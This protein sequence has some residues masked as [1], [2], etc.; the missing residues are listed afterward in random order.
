[1]FPALRVRVSGLKKLSKYRLYL[2]FIPVDRNKYRYVYHR[3]VETN[4]Q[5]GNMHIQSSV[6][7]NDH[8]FHIP[9]TKPNAIWLTTLD[10][11]K[12]YLIN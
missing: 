6:N 2:D 9:S 4:D 8:E 10:C 5:K 3:L 7:G 11:K 1:M 12:K